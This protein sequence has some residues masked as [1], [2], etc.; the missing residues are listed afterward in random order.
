MTLIKPKDDKHRINMLSLMTVNVSRRMGIEM[1]PYNAK[2]VT[3]GSG[4]THWTCVFDEHESR[5]YR[6][7]NGIQRMA[8]VQIDPDTL[9]DL[10]EVEAG[11]RQAI[12]KLMLESN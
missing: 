3:D 12:E 5:I 10:D 1:K 6:T 4:D 9:L 7:Q 11:I 8:D 2:A